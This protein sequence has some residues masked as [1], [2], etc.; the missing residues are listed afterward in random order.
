MDS[1]IIAPGLAAVLL[2]LP[3]CSVKEARGECPVYVTVL[4]ERF[5]QNGQSGGIVSFHAD[6]PIDREEINFLSYIGKGFRQPCPRD[7]ARAA[8][9]S[10][11]EH[12]RIVATALYVPYGE[13][14]GLVWSYG[15]TFSVMADEYRIEA[16]PHKQYCLVKFLFDGEP[17]AP[18]DYPWRFRIKAEC[19]GMDIYTA[20]PLEG[21]YCCPV[22]P[23]AAGEWLGVIPR[24]KRND[25][26]LEV[27]QP[28]AGYGT[29]QEAVYVVDL[30]KRFE[31]KGYDWTRPDLADMTV[32]VGFSAAGIR[33]EV[34]D[35]KGDD[36]YRSIEI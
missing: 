8:V 21:A 31:E 27:F 25:M 18:Q 26:V 24:Q 6:G 20:E 4:T 15:E 29:A 12:E 32:T 23:N 33:I 9:L 13:Q 10:G 5:I 16:V 34:Q 7:Y 35:W 3:C 1:R 22:G 17:Q 2:L 19:C 36:S 28:E 14:A 11:L 30:G